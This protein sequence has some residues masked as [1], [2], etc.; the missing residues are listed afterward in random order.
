[1][2]LFTPRPVFAHGREG[3]IDV[4]AMPR[5]NESI[6]EPRAERALYLAAALLTPELESLFVRL[7]HAKG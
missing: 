7:R 2:M 3:T 6:L 5:A 4:L 1:M